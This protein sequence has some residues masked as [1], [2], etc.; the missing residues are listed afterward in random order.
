MPP[1]QL[2]HFYNNMSGDGGALAIAKIITENVMLNDLRFSATRSM[3]PGC[4]AI[5]EA[6]STLQSLV[7][8]DV[9]DNVFGKKAGTILADA[10]RNNPRLIFLNLRDSG[11][12]EE[13]ATAFLTAVSEGGLKIEYLDLSGNEVSVDVLETSE[14]AFSALTSIKE[15]FLDDNE[16]GSDGAKI[17][18]RVLRR[19]KSL[20]NL[21]V[22]FCD[23]TAAGAYRIAR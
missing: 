4:K 13:G 17:L 10:V 11:L 6:I 15:L 18:A 1:L 9:S 3:K 8:L 22:C 23:L 16:F 12:E 19:L 14:G 7:R 21:S 2:F 5:A 20:T